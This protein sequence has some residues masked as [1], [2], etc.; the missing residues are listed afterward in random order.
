MT[1][2]EYFKQAFTIDNLLRATRTQLEELREKRLAIGGFSLGEKVHSSS[3]NKKFNSLSD[4]YMDLE[5]KYMDDEK[6]LVELKSEM[7]TYIDSLDSPT[8]RLIMTERYINLK[9]WEDVAEDNNY[10]WDTVHRLHRQALEK[11]I[12]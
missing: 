1:T 4:L 3:R 9:N 8:H 5:E 6:R 12:V 2:R 11:I 7:K 10:S